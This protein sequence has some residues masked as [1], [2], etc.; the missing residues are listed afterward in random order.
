MW[1]PG[2]A[3][4]QDDVEYVWAGF[5]SQVRSAPKVRSLLAL[6]QKLVPTQAVTNC[7]MAAPSRSG[8]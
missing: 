8:A 1:M 5:A 2:L 7:L 6:S 3:E 4:A